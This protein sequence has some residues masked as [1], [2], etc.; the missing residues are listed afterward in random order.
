MFIEKI[1]KFKLDNKEFDNLKDAK[2][3]VE[4]VIRKEVLDKINRNIDI[5]HKDLLMLFNII[6]SKDIRYFLIKYLDIKIE[7]EDDEDEDDIMT[8]NILDYKP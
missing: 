8:I 4:D 5:K 6:T 3:Y 2:G 1:N 7:V